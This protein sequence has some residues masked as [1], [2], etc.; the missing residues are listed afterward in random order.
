MAT[1][2]RDL[3]TQPSGQTG[4]G[5]TG[6]LVWEAEVTFPETVVSVYVLDGGQPTR[7]SSPRRIDGGSPRSIYG[8]TAQAMDGGTV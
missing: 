4:S 3:I 2:S 7:W 5:A 1:V 6:I 8:V